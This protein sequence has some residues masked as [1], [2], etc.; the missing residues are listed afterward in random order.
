M[1]S[2]SPPWAVN[3]EGVP[4]SLSPPPKQERDGE[5][6]KDIHKLASKIM[7]DPKKVEIEVSTTSNSVEQKAYLLDG[8]EKLRF[9]Q[10]YF[11]HHEWNSCIIFTATKKGADQLVNALK[12]WSIH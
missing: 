7:K 4:R 2:H 8:R 12:K 5:M 1:P 9:I 10:R 11:G 6:P 3:A